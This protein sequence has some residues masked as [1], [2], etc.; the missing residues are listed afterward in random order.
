MQT[1]DI[2]FLQQYIKLDTLLRDMLNSDRGV[3]DYLE[4]M[5][6]EERRAQILRVP[7]WTEDYH[8]LRQLRHLRNLITHESCAADIS[9]QEDLDDLQA[10][11]QRAMSGDDPFAR[12]EACRRTLEEERA[13]QRRAQRQE[14]HTAPTDPW[15]T[16]FPPT[17][18][19][20]SIWPGVILALLML[21]GAAMLIYGLSA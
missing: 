19:Q 21:A 16:D 20:R 4:T 8:T 12:M 13:Q 15:Q 1:T 11:Y 10:F 9:T 3:S 6:D 5:E 17:P 2:A 14:E 18:K 7:G